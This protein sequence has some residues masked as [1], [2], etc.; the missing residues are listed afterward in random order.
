[1]APIFDGTVGRVGPISSGPLLGCGVLERQGQI[2]QVALGLYHDQGLRLDDHRGRSFA[3]HMHGLWF[4]GD[5]GLN[6]H[7]RVTGADTQRVL[8]GRLQTGLEVAVDEEAPDL[9]VGDR[10]DE[11]FNVD[12]AVAERAAL[13]V[14]LGDLGGEGDDVIITVDPAG[15]EPP[16]QQ[17]RVQVLAAIAQGLA[18]NLIERA[19]DV[20]LKERRLLV[21][22]DR[23]WQ[24]GAEISADDFRAVLALVRRFVPGWG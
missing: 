2:T 3:R 12:A 9:L 17:I 22:E 21:L 16:Y 10:A 13:L 8:L 1:M 19:A 11:V 15:H 18:D 6:V 7:A 20:M 4:G 23:R 24:D 5:G 14:G